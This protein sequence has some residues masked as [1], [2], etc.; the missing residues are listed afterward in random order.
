MTAN[1]ST[2]SGEQESTDNELHLFDRES[3]Y[4][5]VMGEVFVEPDP[6]AVEIKPVGDSAVR[7]N[8]RHA[9]NRRGL[10]LS[11]IL[12]VED[13]REMIDE[14]ADVLDEIDSEG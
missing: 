9:K 11:W 12:S 2:P 13:G 6:A 1:D 10:N 8:T 5:S 4:G 7:I 14:L 3:A